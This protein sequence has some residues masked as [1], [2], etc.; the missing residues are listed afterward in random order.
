MVHCVFFK[1]MSSNN[2]CCEREPVHLFFFLPYY[3]LDLTI[4]L[5]P[6]TTRNSNSL[7]RCANSFLL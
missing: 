4:I 1:D 6:Q 5:S 2:G 3:Y 7:N